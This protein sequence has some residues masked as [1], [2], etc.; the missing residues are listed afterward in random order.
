MSSIRA[1]CRL[2]VGVIQSLRSCL[3]FL[4]CFINHPKLDQRLHSILKSHC[5]ENVADGN[6]GE[7][8]SNIAEEIQSF[9]S[10]HTKSIS[11][12]VLPHDLIRV[13]NVFDRDLDG[14]ISSEDIN[15][16]L[17]NLGLEYSSDIH[18]DT[19]ESMGFD[20]FL[21][22]YKSLWND[23]EDQHEENGLECAELVQVFNVFDRDGD[24]FICASELQQI[25]H[26]LGLKEGN[27][28]SVCESMIKRVDT[29]FDGKVDFAEFKQM[30]LLM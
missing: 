11:A 3:V 1:S 26:S 21:S 13:F 2:I 8:E 7:D 28:V 4:V 30:M 19:R 27:D 20:D 6:G 23:A 18:V 25:L 16:I 12:S 14:L 24:G 17:H 22:L 10:K 29:N 5:N 9:G 15:T